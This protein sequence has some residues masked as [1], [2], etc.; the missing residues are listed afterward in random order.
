MEKRSSQPVFQSMGEFHGISTFPAEPVKLPVFPADFTAS[1]LIPFS[2]LRPRSCI[3]SWVAARSQQRLRPD[4]QERPATVETGVCR[5]AER[6]RVCVVRRPKCC[7]RSWPSKEGPFVWCPNG[8]FL[9]MCK[10]TGWSSSL[11]D[12]LLMRNTGAG[13]VW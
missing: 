7:W 12:V 2:R 6:G 3:E 1:R 10:G 5:G 11:E 13:S 4:L 9:G 8:S